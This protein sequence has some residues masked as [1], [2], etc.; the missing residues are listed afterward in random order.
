MSDD[1]KLQLL[2][3]IGNSQI[4]LPVRLRLLQDLGATP[5]PSLVAGL[6]ALL[7]RR[8]PGPEYMTKN[9]DPAAAEQVVDL[10]IIAALHRLGDD[11]ELSR[12]AMLVRQAGRTLQGP[13][14]E[15]RNAALVILAIG[16]TE[17]ISALIDL[18]S[19]NNLQV[20]RNAVRTLDQL[21][22]PEPPVGQSVASV[23][24]M[25]ETVT[26][27]IRTLG[28]ELQALASLSH[29]AIVLSPGV[30]GFLV[31]HDY[32]RGTVQRENYPLSDIIEKDLSLLDFEYF[33]E[34]NHVTICT[35]GEA[36]ER[37]RHWWKRY[38]AALEHQ[39]GTS[40]FVLRTR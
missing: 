11:S 17:P 15:L 26:F 5:E 10:H 31:A 16:R 24:H 14:D 8:R 39:R 34:G 40:V 9:W 6:K 22:L 36:G 28:E 1:S 13:D 38:G 33:V 30:Q 35:Y 25:S 7:Q 29:S 32:E 23:P 2:Q 18:T 37:W 21:N 20:V 3:V 4:E 27:T 19:D 12:I